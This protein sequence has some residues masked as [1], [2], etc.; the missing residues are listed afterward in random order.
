[1]SAVRRRRAS[2]RQDQCNEPKLYW[3]GSGGEILTETNP[4][5]LKILDYVFFSGRRVAQ[6]ANDF[7]LNGGFENGLTNW[8]TSGP[9]TAAAVNN[10]ANAHSGSYY[11]EVT[12]PV[13]STIITTTQLISAQKGETITATG[14]VY[15]ESGS[16]F[17]S[18]L[19]LSV[20]G[21]GGQCNLAS[22]PPD[23]FTM[24]TWINNTLAIQ[25]PSWCQGPYTVTVNAS[26]W[27]TSSTQSASA[28]FD[29]TLSGNTLSALRSYEK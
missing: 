7:N 8:T 28:R 26:V 2:R 27:N 17:Y 12:S 10:S 25:I 4:A 23:N 20:V 13:N 16:T 18:R 1:M 11:A 3:Y 9:G 22:Q 24:N 15:R 21:D 5:N 19:T 14:W 6:V 29:A